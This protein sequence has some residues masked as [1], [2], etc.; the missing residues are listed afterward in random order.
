MISCGHHSSALSSTEDLYL[1]GTSSFGTVKT[2]DIFHI[3]S[4]IG[5][6]RSI[7]IGGLFSM[8]VDSNGAS[9]IWGDNEKG[10][11]GVGD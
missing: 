8:I 6:I 3:G 11:L 5:K 9:Y 10:E 1:W 4:N 7:A 2:P